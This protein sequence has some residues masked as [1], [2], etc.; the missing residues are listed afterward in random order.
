MTL[1]TLATE[2]EKALSKVKPCAQSR[3]QDS[4][5][6]VKFLSAPDRLTLSAFDGIQGVS[7]SIPTKG[8]LSVEFLTPFKQVYAVCKV[9]NGEIKLDFQDGVLNIS[10]SKSSFTLGTLDL[11]EYPEL[12][13]ISD[14]FSSFNVFNF[15]SNLDLLKKV[16]SVASTDSVKQIL[17]TVNFQPGEDGTVEIAATDTHRLAVAQLD[18][19]ELE[20]SITID[21][22]SLY[23]V[24][25]I[26][27]AK[28]LYFKH[29]DSSLAFTD[30]VTTFFSR[31]V[32]GDFPKYQQLIPSRFEFILSV[33]SDTFSNALNVSTVLNNKSCLVFDFK[34]NYCDVTSGSAEDKSRTRIDYSESLELPLDISTAFNADYLKQ[35]IPS[36][37]FKLCFNSWNQ[38]FVIKSSKYLYLLMPMQIRN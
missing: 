8:K 26:F 18:G 6:S 32:Q 30:G 35:G 36:E 3:L 24:F 20:E 23:S 29:Q 14:D 7:T 9:L 16:A 27:S 5:R 37:D 17:T 12:P 34:E 21:R 4:L 13:I 28:E 15:Q 33:E 1:I 31:I 25:Q 2:L 22:D 11:G 38:P 19:I 10:D